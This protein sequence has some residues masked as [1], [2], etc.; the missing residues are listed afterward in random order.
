MAL[1]TQ[2]PHEL[3][4]RIV[5]LERCLEALHD[6]CVCD[7]YMLPQLAPR[8]FM[9]RLADEA[10]HE[11]GLVALLERVEAHAGQRHLDDVV[12]ELEW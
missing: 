8:A 10:A 7:V 11:E 5:E 3:H 1:Q 2:R 4:R 6:R 9:P 12:H